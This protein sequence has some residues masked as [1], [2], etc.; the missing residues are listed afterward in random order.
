MAGIDSNALLMLHMNGIDGSTVFTDDSEYIRSCTAGGTAQ[1][2]TAQSVFGGASGL[3]DGNSDYVSVPDSDDWDFG[4]GD[5]TIDFRIRFN[6][7]SG[8]QCFVGRPTSG[9][10]YFYFAYEGGGIR[11]RDYPGGFDVNFGNV[12]TFAI[13]TWYHIAI[14]R[15]GNNW[16]FFVD[17]VQKGS[18]ISNSGSFLVRSTTLQIGANTAIGYYVNGW[19]EEV[20]IS[21]V[22]RWIT[23]FDLPTKEY[24]AFDEDIDESLL[25]TDTI[26]VRNTSAIISD[27]LKILDSI[28]L[29]GTNQDA[30]YASKIISINPLIFITDTNPVELV[31][32]DTTNP[33]N[34]TWNILTLYGFTNANDIDININNDYLYIG[35]ANGKLL[36]INL[37]NFFDKTIIDL[38]D[39]DEVLNIEVNSNLG[40]TYASTNNET[41]ELYLIDER[42]KFIINTDL[43]AVSLQQVKIDSF[44]NIVSAFKLDSNFQALSYTYYKIKSD[45]KCL[46]K[47]LIPI[48]SVDDIDPI[49]LTD[50]QVFID[51]IELGNTDLILDSISIT[52]STGE[53]SQASFRLSRR[54]DDL[55]RTLEG[56]TSVITAQNSIEIKI[57]GRTEFSGKI[58]ELDCQYQL[59]ADYVIVK[60][61]AD[62][63][64]NIVQTVTLSVPG[65]NSRL[66]L[67]D[68]LLQNPKIYNPYIDP[69][70]EE[71]PKKYKG[72]RV[73]LGTKIQQ[74]VS[75]YFIPDSFGEI[76]N[77]IIEGTFNPV[78]NWSYFWSPEV[79]KLGDIN[80]GDI[81]AIR[82][83]YIGTSLAP[84]SEDLWKLEKAFHWRQRIWD[85]IET[86][87]GSYEVGEAPFKEI[88]CRNGQKLTKI[89][90]QDEENG[91]YSIKEESYN[92]VN[93]AKK[94]AELEYELLKNINDDILP[95]TSCSFTLTIDAYF[96]YNLSLL[97]KIN[98]DNTI[99]SNIY[100]NLNG[101][102]VSIKS[103]TITSSDR[104]VT[105]EADNKKSQAELE[106]I[107]SQFPDDEDEEYIEPE[108]RLLLHGKSDMKTQLSVE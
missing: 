68:V 88:N 3:L 103:I 78:Q 82:F 70:N 67:Y 22:A 64:E 36:K 41:G 55:N 29:E 28:S 52:H 40:I 95:D 7:V 26:E 100:N 73:N 108:K 98:I 33:S 104:K 43:Q 13:N 24:N 46:T 77:N 105:L 65:I 49:K 93:Y 81:S 63:K 99:S 1:I 15:N 11:C 45:F 32:V 35:G 80:I 54:H 102:P 30:K 53:E 39:T 57:K 90:L 61:L 91:L 106:I 50:F 16:R 83:F 62:E 12:Y 74:R 42:S 86:E 75:S 18:T 37:N 71:N 5:F 84:V 34:L 72:I 66:S 25:I 14:T 31:K 76:A 17:G 4:T 2:D 58:S 97:T 92:F 87:L 85:D 94:V 69:E 60:A 59:N 20:R 79:I 8:N 21:N 6:S 107:N 9:S 56:V 38:N 51:S 48:T 89:K 23:N 47:Q 96:Y 10:S 101:F 19:M 27:S 44:F